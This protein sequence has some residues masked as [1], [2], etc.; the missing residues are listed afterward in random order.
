M[1]GW[2]KRLLRPNIPAKTVADELAERELERI[3][4]ELAAL[5]DERQY[6]RER[7]WKQR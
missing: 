7:Q 1:I 2:L 6:R 4:K 3:D 5:R